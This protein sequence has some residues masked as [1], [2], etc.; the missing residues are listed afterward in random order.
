MTTP[1]VCDYE[2]SDYQ[3]S[4]WDQGGREYEDRAEGI[5]LKRLLPKSGELMLELG[6]GAGR[7]TP[8]YG[9]FER[10]VLVD[11]STTQLQ[12]AQAR[13]GRSGRYIYVAADI[14]RLPFLDGLFDAATMIRALHH[15]ADAPEALAQVQKVLQPGGTFVIEFANKLNLK[16][17]LRYLLR[18]Q[19]WSPFTLEPVEF[20]VLNFDFHPKAIR[21]WLENLGFSIERTLTVSHF[22]LGI[23]KRIVPAKILAALDGLLQPTGAF[24]QLSPSVFV[25][26]VYRG[27]PPKEVELPAS[28]SLLFK[29]LNCGHAPL[30]DLGDY[31]NCVQC[32]SKW[33]VQDGIYDFRTKK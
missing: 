7:N 15:M 12:Q 16:A 25:K 23:L 19:K 32:N 10:V 4:F 20:V 2:G 1:P 6:A 27:L 31:L 14:Y 11:Y 22:R 5:A 24:W 28:S 9:G 3:S 21:Q 29:C 8:R 17:I 33:A 13:L 18:K 30:I 26:A